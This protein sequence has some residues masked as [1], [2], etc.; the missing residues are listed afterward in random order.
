MET[1]V[2]HFEEFINFLFFSIGTGFI[3]NDIQKTTIYCDVIDNLTNDRKHKLSFLSNSTVPISFNVIG[4]FGECVYSN[5][6][7]NM[8]KLTDSHISKFTQSDV[9]AAINYGLKIEKTI[10]KISN[11]FVLFNCSK[12][13]ILAVFSDW[14][15][16][17]LVGVDILEEHISQLNNYRHLILGS[18]ILV[19]E[20]SFVATFGQRLYD[21][22]SIAYNS[23]LKNNGDIFEAFNLYYKWFFILFILGTTHNSE[24]VKRT[25]SHMKKHGR[26][27]LTIE[28]KY[29]GQVSK[30]LTNFVQYLKNEF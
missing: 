26:D 18:W 22:I 12:S 9:D 24:I 4:K 25:I 2:T 23:E 21:F 10:T 16:L 29:N 14:N 1:T 19:S 27:V 30:F 15:T 7:A 28:D 8:T 3:T 11:S 6:S 17:E 13:D 20:K 5:D